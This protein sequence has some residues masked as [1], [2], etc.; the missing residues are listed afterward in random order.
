MLQKYS[1][2]EIENE[3]TSEDECIRFLQLNYESIAHKLRNNEYDRLDSLSHEII[4]FLQYFIEEGPKGPKREIIAQEFCFRMLSEGA[5]YFNKQLQN[6]LYYKA[7][8]AE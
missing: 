4:D 7:Q 1:M 3:K 6:E 2:F 8:F 5:D